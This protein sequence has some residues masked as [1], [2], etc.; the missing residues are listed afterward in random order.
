MNNKYSTLGFDKVY[1]INLKRRSDRKTALLKEYPHI[2]F[3]FIEAIDGKSIDVPKE[4]SKGN[5]HS[6]FYDPNGILTAGVLGCALSHKKAW[7]QALT[8]GVENALF[9]EDD[10][11]IKDIFNES[12]SFTF[13]YQEILKEIEEYDYDIVHLGKKKS[14]S[15]GMNI[16][17]Y[18][19]VS[20]FGTGFEGAHAYAMKKETI[21]HLSDNYLPIRYAADVYIEQFNYTHNLYNLKTSLI[22]Q[23]S[24]FSDPH[25]ADSD[26]YRNDYRDGG[27]KVGISFDEKGNIIDK[28]IAN[29]LVHPP[30]T[31][32]EY[33][34]L[35][36]ER[37]K[38]GTQ[39]INPK[40]KINKHFFSIFN[41]LS[42]LRNNMSVG[43]KMIEINS[44]LGESTFFFGSSNLFSNIYTIDEYKGEDKFNIENN[45]TWDQIKTG[46][47]SNTYF[48]E[49]T[50]SHL[51][52]SPIDALDIIKNNSIEF[53]YI[54]NRKQQ[55]IQTL[56]NQ[57]LPKLTENGIIGGD[58]IEDAPEDSKIF[59][60]GS[61][62]I[63][64]IQC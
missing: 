33:I 5:I 60:D 63:N 21:Q 51:E 64:K 3:T 44:H 37:P 7:D 31:T 62:V 56:I 59:E 58:N 22:R 13:P 30:D 41:L 15:E 29:Y 8:D 55:N 40:T 39:K 61:W 48:F 27:G 23:I 32:Y 1:V 28:T 52:I 54:N 9:L 42:H 47:H 11:V 2:D 49:D 19:T 17:K 46:F 12:K 35:V 57:Y 6:T 10:I 14:E 26:T 38:F 18:L 43:G 16:G 24:D 50:I 4:I 53:I 20:R 25:L 36:L 34:G 45:L